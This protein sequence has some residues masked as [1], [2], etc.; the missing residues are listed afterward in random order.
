M[1]DLGAEHALWY[2]FVESLEQKQAKYGAGITVRSMSEF[3][4]ALLDV[5]TRPVHVIQGFV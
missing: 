2:G 5:S 3:E 4:S 1:P